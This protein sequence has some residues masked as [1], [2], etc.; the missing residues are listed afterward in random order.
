MFPIKN[1]ILSFNTNCRLVYR[2]TIQ[3]ACVC[4]PTYEYVFWKMFCIWAVGLKYSNKELN[5]ESFL[6]D[7]FVSL[8]SDVCPPTPVIIVRGTGSSQSLILADLL[9]LPEKSTSG[10]SDIIQGVRC[11]FVNIYLHNVLWSLIWLL[12]RW[13]LSNVL[14]YNFSLI[15]EPLTHFLRNIW[16]NS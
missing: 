12:D 16:R 3:Y 9:P 11:G 8:T 4:L 2:I 14:L 1:V 6:T 5:W 10:T 7:G 15:T 13:L